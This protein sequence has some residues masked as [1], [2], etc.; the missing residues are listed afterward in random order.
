MYLVNVLFCR[1]SFMDQHDFQLIF[2]RS[3][4]CFL[5]YNS[6]THS[7][8]K[9]TKK[10]AGRYIQQSPHMNNYL[11]SGMNQDNIL[12]CRF[13]L[14]YQ[15]DFQLIFVRGLTLFRRYNS[16]THSN[17][18]KPTKNFCR[19]IQQSPKIRN[20]SRLAM[21]LGTSKEPVGNT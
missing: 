10:S 20:Y 6:R 18:K 12:Y 21:Y 14:M 9:K 11:H 5:R 19:Y 8:M 4:R 7:I 15:L 1:F 13:L 16:R 3:L 17:T 2:E